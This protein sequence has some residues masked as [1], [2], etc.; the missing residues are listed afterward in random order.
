[1]FFV[2][3]GFILPIARFSSSAAHVTER[4]GLPGQNEHS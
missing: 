4:G 3:G 1:L 2:K